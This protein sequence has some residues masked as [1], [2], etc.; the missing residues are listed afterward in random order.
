MFDYIDVEDKF[1]P[2]K[3]HRN[4]FLTQ[5]DSCC[6]TAKLTSTSVEDVSTII[7]HIVFKIGERDSS[8]KLREFYSRDY[9]YDSENEIYYC[10]LLSAFTKNWEAKYKIID[11]FKKEMPYIYEVEVY[12]IDNEPQTV[13]QAQFTILEQ[14]GDRVDG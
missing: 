12:Y 2:D 5:G 13:E 3:F 9:I 8:G 10:P 7:S 11:G 4:Y 14:I 1:K 6:L